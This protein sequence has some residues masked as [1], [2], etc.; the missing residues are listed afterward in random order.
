MAK[1][2]LSPIYRNPKTSEPHHQHPIYPYLLKRLAIDRPDHVWC[3][4][5]T[6]IP[7]RKGFLYLM[8]SWTGRHARL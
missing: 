1:M 3:S 8:R 2:G 6:C 7:M 5:I 4:G